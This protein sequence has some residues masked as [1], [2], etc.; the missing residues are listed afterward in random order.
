MIMNNEKLHNGVLKSL[1]NKISTLM[2][3]WQYE[4]WCNNDLELKEPILEDKVTKY[5]TV[6]TQFS[7]ESFLFES[8]TKEGLLND[9]KV[10]L[11]KMAKD[12]SDKEVVGYDLGISNDDFRDI[13]LGI[14]YLDQPNEDEFIEYQ[15]DMKM[16]Q[17]MVRIKPIVLKLYQEAMK[18]KTE[19]HNK[20]IL[21]Q[22]EELKKELK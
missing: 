8:K 19:E 14:T 20:Q 13:E 1:Y 18:Q 6:T 4:E 15:E 12:F 17:E 16:Y 5:T 3:K 9:I 22:I 2:Y 11:D 10:W 21:A 7:E